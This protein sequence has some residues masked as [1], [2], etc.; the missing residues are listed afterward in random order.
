MADSIELN[1]QHGRFYLVWCV[2]GDFG[3]QV[4][5]GGLSQGAVDDK[6]LHAR[7]AGDQGDTEYW[8]VESCVASDVAI[9]RDERGYFWESATVATKALRAARAVLKME[10]LR[11]KN[12]ETPWP[13]WALQAKA[14]G[15]TA[16]KNWKP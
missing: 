13:E 4:G 14:A 15:W 1:E 2:D 16:P 9:Q 12:K 6:L 5:E 7:R 10:R 11:V 8:A 3:A